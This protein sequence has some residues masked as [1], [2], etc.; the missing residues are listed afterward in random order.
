MTK[1]KIGL[2]ACALA[3]SVACGDST[4]DTD[5]TTTGGEGTGGTNNAASTTGGGNSPTGGGNT[6]GG[7]NSPTGGGNTTGGQS[8]TTGGDDSEGG[9]PPGS[10][11]CLNDADQAIIDAA[12]VP[13]VA[14]EGS[15]CAGK[16]L[17]GLLL[18]DYSGV[19][20]CADTEAPSMKGLSD[21]CR[22]CFVDITTCVPSKCVSALG[23]EDACGSG[24]PSSDF[25]TCDNPPATDAK[26]MACNVKNC[27]PAFTACSGLTD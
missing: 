24:A 9:V 12:G 1:N 6:T 20:M 27:Q 16:N 19:A 11:A 25:A 14:C 26:C 10:G 18:M 2:L 4:S 7:G 8:N 5:D 22:K 15:V 23:G 21:A 3:F 13:R 17:A